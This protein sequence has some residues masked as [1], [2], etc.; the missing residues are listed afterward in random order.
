MFLKIKHLY[1]RQYV[2]VRNIYTN[3]S[4]KYIFF[5]LFLSI[6]TYCIGQKDVNNQS[7]YVA[8]DFKKYLYVGYDNPIYIT[9]GNFNSLKVS[10]DNGLLTFTDNKG[11]FLINP[12]KVGTATIT[13]SGENYSKAFTFQVYP[14]R[15]PSIK[16]T[17]IPNED[18]MIDIKRSEG[19]TAY[20]TPADID[21]L[22]QIDSF[23]VEVQNT[24][25]TIIHTNIGAHWDS[26]TKQ[27]ISNIKSGNRILIYQVYM[28]RN[29]RKMKSD[30]YLQSYVW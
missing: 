27:L 4:M 18:G 26:I 8:T 1:I 22:Y 10:T 12:E 9:T 16:L 29:G 3:T 7:P 11:Y 14:L 25:D 20:Y 2:F 15:N 30:A 19:V 23:T 13:L 5:H 6:S 21:I 28:S 24:N 17:G